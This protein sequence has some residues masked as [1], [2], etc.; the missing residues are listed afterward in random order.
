MFW[1]EKQGFYRDTH[2]AGELEDV[3]MRPNQCVALA[4]GPPSLFQRDHAVLSLQILENE[5]LVRYKL[6]EGIRVHGNEN[7]KS[8]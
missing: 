6:S 7:T 4:V 1:E 5:L 3:Q 2:G 8:F